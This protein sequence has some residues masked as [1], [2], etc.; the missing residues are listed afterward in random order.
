MDYQPTILLNKKSKYVNWKAEIQTLVSDI[1][2]L[3]SY[4]LIVKLR[5]MIILLLKNSMSYW[6]IGGIPLPQSFSKTFQAWKIPF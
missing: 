3:Y 5:K 4:N 2:I 1:V 6:S